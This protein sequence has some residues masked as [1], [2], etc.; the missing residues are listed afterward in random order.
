MTLRYIPM[1]KTKAGEIT[2]LDKLQAATKSRIYPVLHLTQTLTTSYAQQL[3][4]AWTNRPLAVDGN[5][6]FN[7]NGAV[8]DFENLINVLRSRNVDVRPSVSI[9]SDPILITAA[10]AQTNSSG[11]VLKANLDEINR[12]AP[13]CISNQIATNSTDLILDMGHVAGMPIPL[14][15]P[16]VAAQLNQ[17][18]GNH[19]PFRSITLAA[20]AAPKDF[21]ELPRGRS[22]VP[23]LDWQLWEAVS[24][25][26]TL[27]LNYGDYC[28]G[29]PDLTEP[30]GVAM[31]R[32]TVSARYSDRSSWIVIKGHPTT[33]Q[34]GLPMDQQYR[35]HA[36]TLLQEPT[37]ANLPGCWGDQQ[38][39]EIVNNQRRPGNRR[40]WT[41]IA[42]NRHIEVVA[43]QL[44]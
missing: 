12:A 6:S 5:F 38:I 22:V 34:S 44:P 28:T 32:A 23:R 27:D 40:T 33:G 16:I 35:A 37:F 30:P 10:L 25:S 29:H 14:L 41:E 1:L 39:V 20:A 15:A 9:G 4:A 18:V 36:G 13:F 24:K 3:A 17:A 19:N 31:A 7:E 43:A 8:S 11:I 26:V 2:S 21:G 42:V